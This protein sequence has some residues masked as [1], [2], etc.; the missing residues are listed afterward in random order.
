[1]LLKLAKN[2]ASPIYIA[3]YDV[4]IKIATRICSHAS[5]L[6]PEAKKSQKEAV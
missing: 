3:Q 5:L 2:H 4:I 6:K 1:M